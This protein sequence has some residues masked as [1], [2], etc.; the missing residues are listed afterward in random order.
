MPSKYGS[1]DRKSF[2]HPNLQ[3]V[4]S[5]RETID[6]IY[7]EKGIFSILAVLSIEKLVVTGILVEK[8]TRRSF[9]RCLDKLN[10]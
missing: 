4:V 3:R 8:Q 2:D 7:K 10:N 6:Q 5:F 1:K 9:I